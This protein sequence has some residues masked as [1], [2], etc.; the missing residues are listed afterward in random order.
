[1]DKETEILAKTI[2]GE[3][4]GEGLSGMEAIANVVMNRVHKKN[5][6]GQT[7]SEV[8]L[9]PKQ[10]SCWNENDPNGKLI[11][12]DLTTDSV[13]QVCC[14]IAK[15]AIKGL[16]PDITKGSTHYHALSVNPAWA[17]RLVPNAQIGN[18]LFYTCH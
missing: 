17:N 4:R 9:K 16:L 10:F 12:G 18:H 8:C 2:Y 5:W 14:R 13:F 7:I 1:M 15:R 6:W 3:A 11:K